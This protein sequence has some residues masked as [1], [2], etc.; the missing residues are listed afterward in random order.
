MG[1]VVDG[2]IDSKTT[3]KTRVKKK[4]LLMDEGAK[5]PTYFIEFMSTW[6]NEY[7]NQ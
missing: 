5:L 3:L 7:L 1:E 2:R 6:R 4:K